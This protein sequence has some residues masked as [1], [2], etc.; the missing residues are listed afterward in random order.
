[1]GLLLYAAFEFFV[2]NGC[3]VDRVFC[4]GI[5]FELLCYCNLFIEHVFNFLMELKD[6]SSRP[7]YPL[8][9]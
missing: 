9:I 7:V 2:L 8:A 5:V 3:R 6:L 4:S 1:M